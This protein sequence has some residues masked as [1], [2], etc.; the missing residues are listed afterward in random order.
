MSKLP[1]V[2]KKSGE[3][4]VKSYMTNFIISFS[5]YGR[6]LVTLSFFSASLTPFQISFLTNQWTVKDQKGIK[7]FKLTYYETTC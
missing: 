6:P 2:P 5:F 4:G 1:L 3:E 7:G